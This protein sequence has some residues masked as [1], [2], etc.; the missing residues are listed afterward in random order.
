MS[1]SKDK[2]WLR[3]LKVDPIWIDLIILIVSVVFLVAFAT[4]K[5]P[6][7][8]KQYIPDVVKGFTTVASILITLIAFTLNYSYSTCE[9]KA[10]KE[11]MKKRIA[12]VAFILLVILFIIMYSYMSLLYNSVETAYIASGIGLLAVIF[13]FFDTIVQLLFGESFIILVNEKQSA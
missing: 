6:I 1:N 9:K 2:W 7:V 3:I 4:N 13:L 11:W 8:N 10:I 12:F 5:E